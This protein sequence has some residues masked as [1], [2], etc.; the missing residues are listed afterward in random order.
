MNRAKVTRVKAQELLLRNVEAWTQDA[1]IDYV[2]S[3]EEHRLDQLTN[4]E[5]AE[6]LGTEIAGNAEYYEIV[7]EKDIE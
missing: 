6:E 1:L 4:D 3:Y 5:L 7:N 2:Q